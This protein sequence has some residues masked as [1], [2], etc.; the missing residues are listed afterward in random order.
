M[1]RE[2][3]DLLLTKNM[4]SY[5][6]GIYNG[7]CLIK[8]MTDKIEYNKNYNIKFDETN[9][10]LV[11]FHI[12]NNYH[13]FNTTNYID[14]LIFASTTI[15]ISPDY[16]IDCDKYID[17]NNTDNMISICLIL[18]K[19]TTKNIPRGYDKDTQRLKIKQFMEKYSEQIK[20][21]RYDKK[22]DCSITR[23][24]DY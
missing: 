14:I 8:F 23:L 15:I 20:L 17:I 13:L 11:V 4:D 21:I 2:L 22:C 1:I 12:F 6:L 3:L 18:F 9:F 16:Y 5:L 10:K 19:E 7:I 24:L